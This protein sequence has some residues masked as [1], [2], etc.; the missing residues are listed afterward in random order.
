MNP[1]HWWTASPKG[2]VVLDSN[3]L[4]DHVCNNS[5][6]GEWAR[7]VVEWSQTEGHTLLVA[8]MAHSEVLKVFNDLE[9]RQI[10]DSRKKHPEGPGDF[11]AVDAETIRGMN[12]RI[13]ALNAKPIHM[14][15]GIS[16]RCIELR[17][18]IASYDAWYVAIAEER[19]APLFTTDESLV[20]AVGHAKSPCRVHSFR[21]DTE[22]LCR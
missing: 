3:I 7:D 5:T 9:L 6:R 4:S 12:T 10:L 18:N 13:W 22:R 1:F 2:E 19:N 11:A 14:S 17:K 15:Q 8:S 21:T 16:E 20:E